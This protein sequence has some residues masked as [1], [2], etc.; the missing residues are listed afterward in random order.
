MPLLRQMCTP[1]DLM[2]KIQNYLVMI[3]TMIWHVEMIEKLTKMT[4]L[5]AKSL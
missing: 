5:H 1:V 4:A 3:L 2:I